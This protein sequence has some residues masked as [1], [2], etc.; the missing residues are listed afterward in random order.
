MNKQVT[1]SFNEYCDKVNEEIEMDITYSKI[2]QI[3][4]LLTGYKKSTSKCNKVTDEECE[5]YNKTNHCPIYER[6][7]IVRKDL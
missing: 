6:E 1:I 5:Y 3:G 7:P 2:S 4:T